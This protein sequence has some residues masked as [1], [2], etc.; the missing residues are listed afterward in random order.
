M[1]VRARFQV[2]DHSHAGS[3]RRRRHWQHALAGHA[4]RANIHHGVQ[5]LR[6][7]HS[8]AATGV[9]LAALTMPAA[10]GRRLCAWTGRRLEWACRVWRLYGAGGAATRRCLLG[11]PG[12]GGEATATPEDVGRKEGACNRRVHS[13]RFA[14]GRRKSTRLPK[15][16]VR[17]VLCCA[18]SPLAAQSKPRPPPRHLPQPTWT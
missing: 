10:L 18:H 9:R 4:H 15:K 2:A 16:P 13:C 7:R 8:G 6:P 3:R 11:V 5:F 1:F 14:C 17:A 12:G